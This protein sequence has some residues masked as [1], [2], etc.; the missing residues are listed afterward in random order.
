MSVTVV[1]PAKLVPVSVTATPTAP[2]VPGVK[3]VIAGTS[4]MKEVAKIAV[5]PDVV[6]EIRPEVAP[7]GT[8]AVMRFSFTTVKLLTLVVLNL[9]AVAPV[10]PVPV[11]VTTSPVKPLA[12]VKELMTG[13]TLKMAALVAVPLGVVKLKVPVVALPGTVVVMLAA[14]TMV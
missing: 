8:V 3:L 1:A 5:P 10:K 6:T 13:S 4:T 2:P 7:A 12:D 11:K 14:E 9:T